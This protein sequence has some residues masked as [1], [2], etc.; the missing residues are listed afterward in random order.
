MF[1]FFSFHNTAMGFAGR[2]L[3]T[4]A[5]AAV[6]WGAESAK[7]P[8]SRERLFRAVEIGGLSSD[9]FIAIV[10]DFGVEF[11]LNAEDR[12]NLAKAGVDASVVAAI[13]AN[14]RDPIREKITQLTQGGPLAKDNIIGLLKAGAGPEIVEA[15][16][17]KRGISFAMTPADA[18]EIE[19]AGGSKGLL[20]ALL[21]KEPV[22]VVEVASAPTPAPA[23]EPE[24]VL[25]AA[26]T[27]A[28]VVPPPLE[29]TAPEPVRT[30]PTPP[31]AA[32]TTA[33]APPAPDPAVKQ[34]A[35]MLTTSSAKPAR[36]IKG[37][38]QYND[39]ARR[40]HL[41]GKVVMEFVINEQGRL[42]S[43]K[44]VSGNPLLVMSAA[45]SMKDWAYEPA[46][47]D[48]RPTKVSTQVTV[49]FQ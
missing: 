30:T 26:A 25:I 44:G 3:V 34:A 23:K 6:A 45:Q 32:L 47:V 40:Q 28:A 20:G 5:V 49:D 1:R 29:Q 22:K 41:T 11:E 13:G 43:I 37:G 7:K 8:I 42:E 9:E 31:A 46:M 2:L 27:P 17:D 12:Q 48:G 18:K 21:L 35:A 16:I 39:M 10:K 19:T 36:L 4:G 24:P 33:P 38:V 14:Y 15:L